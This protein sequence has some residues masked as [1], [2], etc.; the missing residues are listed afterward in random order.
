MI[1]SIQFASLGQHTRDVAKADSG[2]HRWNP[3]HVSPVPFSSGR[4][5]PFLR[6]ANPKGG[7]QPDMMGKEERKKIDES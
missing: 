5:E 4:Q 1:G 7:P 3:P 6:S 2:Q